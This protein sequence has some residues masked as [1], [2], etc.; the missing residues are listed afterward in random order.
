MSLST[1]FSLSRNRRLLLQ[2]LLVC[3]LLLASLPAA[4][5]QDE[6]ITLNFKEAELE[7]VINAVARVTG[8]TFVVDPAVRGNV[9]IVSSQ[10]LRPEE[11]YA[12][13]LSILQVHDFAAI[14]AGNVIKIVPMAKAG[15]DLVITADGERPVDLPED[16][17]ITRI[18]R[19]QNLQADKLVPIL[20]PLL[21]VRAGQMSALAVKEGNALIITERA[22]NVERLLQIVR[23]L[24]QVSGSGMEMLRL[25]HADAREVVAVI[26]GL[27]VGSGRLSADQLRL[28]ADS[29]TN[30]ILMQGDEHHLLRVKAMILHL[31]T[32]L[33]REGDTKVVFLRYANAKDLVPIL[34]GMELPE[35]PRAEGTAAQQRRT[36]Q[37]REDVNI[38]ADEGTNALIMTGPPAVLTALQGVV[39]QLDIRRV[40][41]MIEA[42]I[43]EVST[44]KGADL[45]IQWFAA[46]DSHT[47]IVAATNFPGSGRVGLSGL[48]AGDDAAVGALAGQSGFSLGVFSGTVDIFGN[49]FFSL[50]ALVNALATDA[51]TNILS[52]PSLVTMDNHEAEIVVGQ[53]VPFLT[54]SFTQAT[55][56][57]GGS[58]FQTIER[59][60]VGIKLRVKPQ[61]NEG[62]VIRLDIA[63][64]VSSVE[65]GSLEF[66]SGLIT[67]TRNITT[68]VLVEDGKVLVLGGLISD[69]VQESVSKVPVL[70][71]LPVLGA[72]FRYT[73][74]RRAKRNLMVFLRPVILRDQAMS[75]QVSL[76]KYDLIRDKQLE[77][78]PA[79][80]KLLPEEQQ[81]L[82]LEFEAFEDQHFYEFPPVQQEPEQTPAP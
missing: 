47:G 27:E 49:E 11:V 40:Q 18:Y 12:V 36:A 22:G 17:I 46:D 72:L 76:D 54:G 68:S 81:P 67:N 20:R 44:S 51:D 8:K 48:A 5:A 2:G 75:S 19:L 26:T 57:V 1:F 39:R 70:G 21:N 13:F 38:Q 64:E 53:N 62:D 58:P 15:Q 50:G 33:I 56:G 3:G 29:R 42:V 32:P 10:P 35:A 73:S 69:D 4:H 23:R 9:T 79:G 77:R 59:R 71:D 6:T 65:P 43:A 55:T 80:V 61:I 31:D 74:S 25:E 45:G 24:D 78:F 14:E 52:T 82:L 28:A 41:L 63:Q 37:Q 7:S 34:S 60:D 30:S 66:A 16:R